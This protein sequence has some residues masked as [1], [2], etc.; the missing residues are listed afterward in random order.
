MWAF[1]LWDG[2][3]AGGAGG[4]PLVPLFGG[5][6]VGA[7][8]RR[9]GRSGLTVTERPRPSGSPDLQDAN[10]LPPRISYEGAQAVIHAVL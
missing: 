7:S 6:P 10:P 4:V 8:T 3:C 9:S 2:G 5:F 1:S